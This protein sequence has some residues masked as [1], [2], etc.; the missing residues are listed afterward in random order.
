[1]DRVRFVSGSSDKTAMLWE[2]SNNGRDFNRVKTLSG[3]GGAVNSVTYATI[4]ITFRSGS[5]T[6]NSLI[7]TGSAD[8][9]AKIWSG[10]DGSFLKT[11]NGHPGAVTSVSFS[12]DPSSVILVTGCVDAKLRIFDIV[13][14]NLIRTL[15]GHQGRINFVTY[16]PASGA[17]QRNTD[18]QLFNDTDVQWTPRTGHSVTLEPADASADFRLLVVVG[19]ETAPG[20]FSDEVWT[21]RPDVD[22]DP[23]RLDYTDNALFRSGSGDSLQ[24]AV[25]SPSIHYV[26]EDSPLSFLKRFLLPDKVSK[27]PRTGIRPWIKFPYI[28]DDRIEML[29]SL[30]IHTI[31]EFAE[32]DK[33]VILKLRGYDF[34]G[35]PDEERLDY[36]DVCDARQLAIAIVDMC[37]VTYRS[38]YAGEIQMP[39]YVRNEFGDIAPTKEEAEDDA[40][41]PGLPQDWHGRDFADYFPL[42]EYEE[43]VEGWDGC[44]ALELPEPGN[45]KAFNQFPN[46]NGLGWVLPADSIADPLNTL[47]ELQCK[48]NPGSRAYHVGL[49]YEQRTYIFGGKSSENQFNGDTWYRDDRLP[50]ATFSKRP[51]DYSDEHE[52]FFAYDEPGCSFEYRLW[53]KVN[54]VQLLQWTP[55]VYKADVSWLDWRMGGPGDGLYTFFV[56]AVDPAGNRD[57]R[58]IVGKNFVEWY[59][60]SPIPWDI[61]AEGVGGFLALCLFGYLEY[62]R[63]MKKAAMERYAMKRMRRKFKAMQR[64]EEGGVVDWRTLYNES[65]TQDASKRK[66]KKQEREEKK[67]EREKEKKKRDKEKE[68]IKKK[69]KAGKEHK[70]KQKKALEKEKDKKEMKAVKDKDKKSKK[71]IEGGN[72]GED[73]SK[74]LKDYEKGGKDQKKLKDYEKDSG[75]PSG[76]PGA[77]TGTKQRKSNKRYKDYEGGD[78]GGDKKDI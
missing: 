75:A 3:H 30:G 34:P 66:S 45:P 74:K 14:G 1:M 47:Q 78:D 23:W 31:K 35:V 29:N 27:V 77:E 37:S 20:E 26:H 10:D 65:K 5:Q 6:F 12:P 63:R 48:V 39:Q 56:R 46:V 36:Y 25:D 13:T 68:N 18:W 32:A 54:Y 21:L 67:R 19:G 16:A 24:W 15:S 11:L 17:L 71:A 4:G 60:Y 42:V 51:P 69:L 40:E 44:S 50:T 55:V 58:Y 53:D 70:D 57:E 33:Y 2:M 43:L 38:F 7:A 72:D 49:L 76:D 62:R 52:F 41:V 22:S 59:Y 8:G 64:D 73:D 28:T 9:T 61:I